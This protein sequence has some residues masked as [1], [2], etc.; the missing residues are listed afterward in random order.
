MCQLLA[1]QSYIIFIE[2]IRFWVSG[3]IIIGYWLFL[4]YKTQ[5]EVGKHFNQNQ[6]KD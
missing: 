2:I 1:T 4:P 3:G 5:L 6:K